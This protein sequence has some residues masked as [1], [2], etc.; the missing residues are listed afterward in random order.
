M[1]PFS[2]F[3]LE[4]FE[5]L[6]HGEGTW[7]HVWL[8]RLIAKADSE[9]LERLR[10]GFPEEVAAYERWMATGDARGDGP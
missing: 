7:F 8:A 5:D 3:D 2:D 1:T 6:L 10:V 4:N 9:N